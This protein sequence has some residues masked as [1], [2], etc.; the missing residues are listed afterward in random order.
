M[1]SELKEVVWSANIHLAKSGLAIITWG[2]VSGFDRGKSLVVI[3]PSGV[4]YDEMKPDDMVVVNIDGEKVEGK[5]NPSSDTPTHLELYRSLPG[6]GGIVHTHSPYACGWAQSGRDIPAMGTT[7]A[8]HFYGDI[9]C[10]RKLTHAEVESDYELNTAKVIM[11]RFREIDPSAIPG[12]LVNDHGPFAWGQDPDEAVTNAIALEEVA[13]IALVS[14]T[15]AGNDPIDDYLLDK[16][17]NRK[18]GR[19]AYYGQ[20]RK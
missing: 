11:E 7:H 5:L 3:K 1:L 6:I 12:V 10:T 9:P 18:H 17:Y 4:N 14:M 19:R 2:N 20:K 13:K 15:I 8:D 16:H